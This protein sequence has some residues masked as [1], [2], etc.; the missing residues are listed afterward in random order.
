MF[1][2]GNYYVDLALLIGVF[3]APNIFNRA[4]HLLQWILGKDKYVCE[5]D[6]QHYH[7]D[8]LLVGPP[9]SNSCE[10]G[11]DTCLYI[12]DDLGVPMEPSKTF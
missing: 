9:N 6:I 10:L 12:C 3:G 5:N 4:E 7:D 2:Q 1:W 11:L 8:F